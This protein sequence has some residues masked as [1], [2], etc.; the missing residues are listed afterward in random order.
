MIDEIKLRAAFKE[1]QDRVSVLE[2]AFGSK[3]SGNLDFMDRI[4]TLEKTVSGHG[5][6][7]VDL[8]GEPAVEL[9]TTFP[10]PKKEDST[11]GEEYKNIPIV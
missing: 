9:H 3:I 8:R 1:L 11:L 5:T 2:E 4:L 10:I 6:L 7:L